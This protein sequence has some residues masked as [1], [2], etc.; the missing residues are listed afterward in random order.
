MYLVTVSIKKGISGLFFWGGKTC[1]DLSDYS[2]MVIYFVKEYNWMIYSIHFYPIDVMKIII[3]EV[4]GIV[5]VANYDILSSMSM[6]HA[7]NMKET[8]ASWKFASCFI[9]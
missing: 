9:E 8:F 2:G 5:N 3:K 1:L 4:I 7:A 6:E